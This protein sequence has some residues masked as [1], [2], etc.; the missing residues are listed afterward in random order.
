[1]TIGDASPARLRRDLLAQLP[2]DARDVTGRL[3]GGVKG[4]GSLYAVGG[5]IHTRWTVDEALANVEAAS[6]RDMN[7]LSR[8]LE[9]I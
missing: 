5:I 7:W 2:A 3:V 4:R 1:M 6:G 8:H 9:Q